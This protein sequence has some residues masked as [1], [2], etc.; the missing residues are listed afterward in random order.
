MASRGIRN[1]GRTRW[2]H[3]LVRRRQTPRLGAAPGGRVRGRRRTASLPGSVGVQGTRTACRRATSSRRPLPR[4]SAAMCTPE[5]RG[6]RPVAPRWA[7]A[8]YLAPFGPYESCCEPKRTP[9]GCIGTSTGGRTN[10]WEIQW[11]ISIPIDPAAT[12]APTV[13]CRRFA[14]GAE[15]DGPDLD[16]GCDRGSEELCGELQDPRQG[17]RAVSRV[18]P[19]SYRVMD[20]GVTPSSRASSALVRPRR[21]RAIRMRSG[22]RNR[23]RRR[24]DGE[25][26]IVASHVQGPTACRSR[27]RL[28]RAKHDT[29]QPAGELASLPFAALLIDAGRL[30]HL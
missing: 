18:P 11:S 13:A 21:A 2:P 30:R 24:D 1:S 19:D 8:G 12:A 4:R 5:R 20:R 28:V 14:G 3:V 6:T 27:P 15:A 7:V 23:S 17:F 9:S 26:D 16:L 25:Y 10:R 22:S 29:D